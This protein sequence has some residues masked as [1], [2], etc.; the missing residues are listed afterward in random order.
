MFNS[1]KGETI[2]ILKGQMFTKCFIDN[3]ALGWPNGFELCPDSLR[4]LIEEQSE[5]KAS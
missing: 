1:P 4:M 2:D 5:N 3:G